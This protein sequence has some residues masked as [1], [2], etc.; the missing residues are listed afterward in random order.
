MSDK[1]LYATLENAEDPAAAWNAAMRFIEKSMTA[2]EIMRIIDP[3]TLQWRTRFEANGTSY[4][5]ITPEQGLPLLRYTKLRAAL[6]M[7]GFD[8]AMPDMMQ[9]LKKMRELLN[10]QGKSMTF[11][12]SVAVHNMMETVKRSDRN[13]DFA[14]WAATLF[15]VRDG[16]DLTRYDE[17]D[18]ERKIEDWNAAKIYPADFFLCCM[19]WESERGSELQRL[20]AKVLTRI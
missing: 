15:I 11:D 4:R 2:P 8:S 5:I 6:A 14:T 7:V 20:S 12:L 18:A 10:A 16:E 13:W 3:D 1:D 19:K 9:Q 17:A